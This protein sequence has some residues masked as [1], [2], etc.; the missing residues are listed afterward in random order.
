IA[1]R[2]AVNGEQKKQKKIIPSGSIASRGAVNSEQKKQKKI[3][4]SGSIAT[5][6]TVSRIAEFLNPLIP[7]FLNPSIRLPAN[8][9]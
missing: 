7:K 1:S 9:G 6:G 4:S 5:R 2:G 3:I 8:S